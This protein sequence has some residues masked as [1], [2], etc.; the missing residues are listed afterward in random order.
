MADRGPGAGILN[1][2]DAASAA[3]IGRATGAAG[4]I[5]DFGQE[6]GGE[7][8]GLLPRRCDG[9]RL[10]GAILANVEADSIVYIVGYSAYNKLSLNDFRHERVNRDETLEEAE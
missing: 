3:A 9:E 4:K 6:S 8:R 2:C 7:V 5:P 10:I 1:E